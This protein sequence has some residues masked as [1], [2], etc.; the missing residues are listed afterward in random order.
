VIATS[1]LQ[2]R[3]RELEDAQARAE[4]Y[5]RISRGLNMAHDELDLLEVLSQPA[6]TTGATSVTLF[7][8]DL[9]LSGNPNWAEVAA[10]W[11]YDEHASFPRGSR[12]QL[13][14]HPLTAIWLHDYDAPFI[15]SDVSRDNRIPAASFTALTALTASAI[16]IVPLCYNQKWIGLL[17]MLW[18]TSHRCSPGEVVAYQAMIELGAAVVEHYR[19]NRAQEEALRSLVNFQEIISSVSANFIHLPVEQIDSGIIE[20]LRRICVYA[21]AT[22]GTIHIVTADKRFNQTHDWYSLLDDPRMIAQPLIPFT[23]MAYI[24][25]HLSRYESCSFGSFG[26]LPPEA[27]AE[28]AWFQQHGFQPC[29]FI[30]MIYEGLLYGIISLYGPSDDFRYWP[31]ELVFLQRFIA[32]MLINALERKE[33]EEALRSSQRLF[34]RITDASPDLVYVYDLRENRTI[35]A[36]RQLSEFLGIADAANIDIHQNTGLTHPRDL[37][38]LTAQRER[39]FHAAD[40]EVLTVEYRMRGANDEWFWFSQREVVF[41]R[42]VDGFPAQALGLLQ[43]ITQR[44]QTEDELSRYRDHLEERVIERTQQLERAARELVEAKEIAETANRA[45]SEFLAR[46][47]H[48]L[49][50]PLNGILGYTNILKREPELTARQL[51]GLNIIQQSGEHL[52]T[53]I[54]DILDLSRIEVQRMELHPSDLYLPSF[55]QSIAGI[56]KLGAEQRGLVFCY[57]ADEPL[58]SGIR[59][60]T[61]RLRQILLNLLSN[62]VKFTDHGQIRFCVRRLADPSLFAPNEVGLRFEVSDTG[63]GI[64]PEKLRRIFL[65]FEQAADIYRQAE[66]AGLGLAISQRLVQMMGSELHVRSSIGQGSI[67]WFDLTLP[68]SNEALAEPE[69]PD[70][71]I[72]G[73]QGRRRLALLVDDQASNRS[74]LQSLLD[75]LGFASIEAGNGQEAIEQARRHRP[76]FIIMDLVMPVMSGIEA[77]RAIR[78]MP[79]FDDTLIIAS[80]ASVFESDRQ[81]SM[82]AGCNVFLPK[83]IRGQQLLDI[84]GEH[85]QLQWRYAGE[86]PATRPGA[87][88]AADCI[89]PPADVLHRLLELARLG[90]MRGIRD[91]A[92][93]LQE[94]DPQYRPFARHLQDLA[95]SYEEKAVLDVVQHYLSGCSA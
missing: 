11:H 71:A 93:R 28:Q 5:Y 52:L 51:D 6:R 65:P 42:D 50:T 38:R 54:N 74:L 64:P 29:L 63:I 56:I 21:G 68:L 90:D 95:R 67:F 20:A 91:Q 7:Y 24:W 25:S 79:Q 18:P 27:G 39:F 80:S 83:P 59:A 44:R 12:H 86:P 92:H 2:Q 49:R 36:S 15:C 73:Y 41:T 70:Q 60:D 75:P 76:D 30:P 72:I 62:A 77:T 85:L 16:V 88:L 31:A 66:G 13:A 33:S 14:G 22:R 53:I 45:K 94:Q 17:Q 23:E 26:D 4:I 47:S 35:F 8:L 84:I 58:P 40:G 10:A 57:Q 32:D 89:A 37:P 87:A 9:D 46:M 34:R 82:L 19:D 78:T 81:Q 1:D 69:L 3:I 48:E 55:L 61:M 43:D